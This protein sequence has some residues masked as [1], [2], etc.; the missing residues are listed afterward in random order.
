MVQV[1]EVLANVLGF[2]TPSR[3]KMR[4]CVPNV[5]SSATAH[6]LPAWSA[7]ARRYLI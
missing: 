6:T 1:L 3:C 5:M 2:S 7:A 4:S